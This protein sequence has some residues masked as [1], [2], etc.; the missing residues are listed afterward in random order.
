MDVSLSELQEL[1]MDRE[2]WRAAIHGVTES[3]TTEQLNWT[4]LNWILTDRY[5]IYHELN[6]QIILCKIYSELLPW[7][8]SF[9]PEEL[10]KLEESKHV[11]QEIIKGQEA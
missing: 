5:F 7:I 1:V 10:W 11:I 6:W 3:D 8:I 9:E 2:A 4:E